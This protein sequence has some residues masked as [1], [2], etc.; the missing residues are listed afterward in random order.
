MKKQLFL[1]GILAFSM[2]FPAV[3]AQAE[4][5][6]GWPTFDVAKLASL[7]TNLVARS[8]VVPQTVTRVNQVKS[9]IGQIQGTNQAAIARDLKEM[10]QE[11]KE[12][13]RQEAY[14]SKKEKSPITEAAKGIN[15]AKDASKKVK[16]IL[17]V[18]SKVKKPTDEEMKKVNDLRQ[19]L[20]NEIAYE[21]LARSLYVSVTGPKNIQKYFQKADQ[22]TLQAQTLQ[23]NINA[24]TMMFMVGNFGRL[25]QISLDLAV[26]RNS[27]YSQLMKTPVTGYSKPVPI[28][29]LQMGKSEYNEQEK[30]EVDVNFE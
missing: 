9:M 30:D 8:R 2:M 15:G 21:T 26:L 3:G 16:E 23:D 14:S 24:N 29:G 22:A 28:K 1:I 7:V 27:M 19:R 13:V 5:D 4:E 6:G 25:N 11:V 17:F 12:G 20:K 18:S 10:T